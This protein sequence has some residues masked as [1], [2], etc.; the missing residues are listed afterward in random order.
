M[1]HLTRWKLPEKT[2][3]VNRLSCKCPMPGTGKM[4]NILST[5]YLALASGSNALYV[6]R[7]RNF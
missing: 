7:G 6:G 3:R 2:A 4:V 5:V 1:L